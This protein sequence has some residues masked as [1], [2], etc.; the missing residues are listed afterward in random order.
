MRGPNQ[1]EPVR[2]AP[3]AFEPTFV[4]ETLTEPGANTPEPVQT[5]AHEF[6]Q[7]EPENTLETLPEPTA[8]RFEPVQPGSEMEFVLGEVRERLADKD[9]EISF[10]RDQLADAQVEIGKRA[11]STDEALKTIDRVVRSFELQA[12]ANRALALGS[13][14]VEPTPEQTEPIRFTAETVDNRAGHQDIRRV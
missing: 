4:N 1:G 8:N 14:P 11:A 13:A 9:R 2:T 12:E 3:N 5:R 10:L 6:E 7:T